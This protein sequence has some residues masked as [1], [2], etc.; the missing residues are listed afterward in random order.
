MAGGATTATVQGKLDFTG[1]QA[2]GPR[3]SFP[4]FQIRFHD[5]NPHY[6]VY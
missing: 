5:P 1:A 4:P 2:S 6:K 3:R